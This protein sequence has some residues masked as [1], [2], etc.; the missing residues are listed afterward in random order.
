[1]TSKMMMM[2]E[3]LEKENIMQSNI[4]QAVCYAGKV[5]GGTDE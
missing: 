1:M 5:Q 4:T 3:D 2:I